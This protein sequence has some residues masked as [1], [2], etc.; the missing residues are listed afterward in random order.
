MMV[1][2]SKVI[3]V[4]VVIPNLDKTCKYSPLFLAHGKSPMGGD[5]VIIITKYNRKV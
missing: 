1:A 2:R 5:V 4:E 3:A